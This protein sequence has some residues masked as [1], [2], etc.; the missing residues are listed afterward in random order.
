MTSRLLENF[1][2]AEKSGDENTVF[3]NLKILRKITCIPKTEPILHEILLSKIMNYLDF[4]FDLNFVQKDQM[5]NEILWI[6]IN[7]TTLPQKINNLFD[8]SGLIAKLLKKMASTR[9]ENKLEM[10]FYYNY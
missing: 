7:L 3:E 2:K 1:E 8:F 9:E 5:E 10:V 6:Y 4:Y